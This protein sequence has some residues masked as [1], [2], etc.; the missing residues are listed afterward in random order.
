MVSREMILQS[1]LNAYRRWDTA[2]SR[3]TLK[4]LGW[5][6]GV[7]VGEDDP[8]ED[9]VCPDVG[10]CFRNHGSPMDRPMR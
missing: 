5:H 7:V 10:W 6:V 8:E 3:A 1:A 2:I 9:P 4:A